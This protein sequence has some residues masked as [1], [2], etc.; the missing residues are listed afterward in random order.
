[1][2]LYQYQ[3]KP[4][5]LILSDLCLAINEVFHDTV[6]IYLHGSLAMNCHNLKKS[7]IDIIAVVGSDL[8]LKTELRFLIEQ[9]MDIESKYDTSIEISIVTEDSLINFIH[10]SRFI[11]HY[12]KLQRERYITD[13]VYI[14][15]WNDDPDLAAH[16]YMIQQRGIALYGQQINSLFKGKYDNAYWN[17]VLNDISCD[18]DETIENQVYFILN[19]C[20]TLMYRENGE[21]GSKLEGGLWALDNVEMEF[22]S[23]VNSAI[24]VY[25][26]ENHEKID[27]MEFKKFRE[28]VLS[29]CGINLGGEESI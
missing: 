10:P 6:G 1:M 19:Y 21:V 25:K 9:M 8:Q 4:Y 26:G 14:C 22:R 17:S 12:S 5:N 13:L 15:G 20:R 11:I 7:D 24:R 29:L 3:Q 27:F 16:F 18:V 28:Y 2:E 23:L